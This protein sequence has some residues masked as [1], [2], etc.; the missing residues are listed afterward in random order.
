MQYPILKKM[1][2]AGCR[3][4]HVG[5]ESANQTVLKNIKKGTTIPQMKEFASAANKARIQ[6]HADFAIGYIGD[7]AKAIKETIEFAKEIDTHTAQFQ[8]FRP[9]QGTPDGEKLRQTGELTPEGYPNY[10]HISEEE[11]RYWAKKA[12]RDFYFRWGYIKKGILNP[13]EY[14]FSR[15]D[16]MARAIPH[17]LWKKWH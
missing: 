2:E 4:L 5:F 17:F 8:L 12:Y 3:N 16:Q 14:V 13:Q 15:I 9:L 1:K 7:H 11:L 6:I 10:Q